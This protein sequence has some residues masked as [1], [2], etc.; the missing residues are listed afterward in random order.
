MR[1]GRRGAQRAL[2]REDDVQAKRRR[3]ITLVLGSFLSILG[4]TSATSLAESDSPLVTAAQQQDFVRVRVL[5]KAG[6]D[7]NAP[8]PDGATALL[9]AAHWNHVET[10]DFL[11]GA[12]ADANA[13]D[14]QGVTP[15]LLACENGSP[16][17]VEKLLARGADPNLTQFNGVSPLMMAA[18]GGKLAVVQPLLARGAKV[19]ATIDATGQTALMWATAERHWP[20]MR[21]LIAAGAEVNARSKI[22]FTPLLFAARN[23]DIDAAKILLAAGA[24]V[25]QP[26]ADG[27]HALPLAIVS[28]RGDFA[29]F[30]IDQGADPNGTMHGVGA[31][32]AAAGDVDSWLRDWLRARGASVYA[33]NS[34]GLTLVQ[35]IGVVKALIAH[36]ADPNA[37]IGTSTVMGLGVTGRYG[38]FDTFS[39]GTGDLKGATPLWVAAFAANSSA[40]SSA[41][42]LGAA[43]IVQ[44]LLEAGADPNLTTADGTT[45]L[46]VA[47]GLGRSSYQPGAARGQRSA[48][49]E[50]AVRMLVD[51]GAAVNA[52]NEAGFTALHGAAFRGLNEVIQ[53]LVE[54]GGNLD[55]QDFKGRTPYRVAEG[56]QQAFRFQS[57]PETAAFLRALGADVTLGVDG[58]ALDR[59]EARRAPGAQVKP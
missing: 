20:I 39:V 35:R 46:M 16:A 37:R 23:G 43:E 4:P 19:D 48:S 11:L 52:T 18:R 55:A 22:G 30:L 57:W 41:S 3:S 58:R 59:E 31:L 14:D 15:L 26:G 17:V 56:A 27:T 13:Q 38:A 25:N 12:G 33:R 54:R 29:M 2:A 51:A 44:L 8:R 32:H 53:Y 9:W 5:V 40:A 24:R 21:A 45:P 1:L 47:A 10:V 50:S 6:A 28:G 34:S 7:V 42:G 49:A 36:G